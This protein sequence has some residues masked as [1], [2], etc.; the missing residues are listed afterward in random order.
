MFL[1][2]FCACLTT[3]TV[4]L[5]KPVMSEFTTQELW[6]RTSPRLRLVVGECHDEIVR[7]S[8]GQISPAKQGRA[9]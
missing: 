1:F 8:S 7:C 9:L 5:S 4:G 3:P 2:Y 6:V